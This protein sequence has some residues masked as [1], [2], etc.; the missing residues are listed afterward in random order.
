M[1]TLYRYL[2]IVLLV[3]SFFPFANA[4][5]L[6][7][8]EVLEVRAFEEGDASWHTLPLS[9]DRLRMPVHYEAFELLLPAYPQPM[10]Y[11]IEG[12]SPQWS[13]L[14]PAN[15][16]PL[17][18]LPDGEYQLLL[19]P[20]GATAATMALPIKAPRV[21]YLQTWFLLSF[22]TA[23]ILKVIGFFRWREKSLRKE[24]D[25][26][27]GEVA[28]RTAEIEADKAVI[29]NQ[30]EELESANQT[31]DKLLAMIGHELRGPLYYLSNLSARVE[32]L[33]QS[34][35][36]EKVLQL[37]SQLTT[38][39]RNLNQLMNN[40]LHWSLL[41]AGKMSA[42]KQ[43]VALHSIIDHLLQ[44]N[45][46][47]ASMKKV[48]I[49]Q[50]CQ[51]GITVESD[52][53]GLTIALQNLISNAVKFTPEGGEVNI[54][55]REEARYVTICV[56]DTGVGMD[57]AQVRQ[58]FSNS[59]NESQQGTA[60]ERGTGIG[61]AIAHD[62]IQLN[63][64]EISVFSKPGKGSAFEVRLPKTTVQIERPMLQERA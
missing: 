43:S 14:P 19:R 20:A 61:L 16:L 37:T 36:P 53:Q 13:A 3:S 38:S 30:K 60:G 64:G 51:P 23:N 54:E 48:A 17:H 63:K 9:P 24:R 40:L 10:E 55:A 27:E 45:S 41:Q 25:K 6:P 18:R 4:A 39:T 21:W 32:Y 12:L 44:V 46:P 52:Q 2:H 7:V 5:Q 29:A 50:N 57:D 22:L 49:R 11:K 26:L 42:R 34:N 35:K 28:A 62:L 47:S 8:P 15:K 33:L 1:D 31:K 59:I 58:L 56:K